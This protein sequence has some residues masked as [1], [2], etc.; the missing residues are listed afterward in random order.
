[1]KREGW[2]GCLYLVLDHGAKHSDFCPEIVTCSPDW[3]Q[4]QNVTEGGPELQILMSSLPTRGLRR[5]LLC[6]PLAT[7]KHHD[8]CSFAIDYCRLPVI[9][10]GDIRHILSVLVRLMAADFCWII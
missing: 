6:L 4:A 1:M 3:P 8:S 2:G 10:L 7:L 5:A 9:D